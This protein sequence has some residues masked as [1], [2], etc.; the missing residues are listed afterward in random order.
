MD[1]TV[2]LSKKA[3]ISHDRVNS[4][5]QKTHSSLSDPAE[6]PGVLGCKTVLKITGAIQRNWVWELK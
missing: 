2:P 5:L 4:D 6:L 1:G 3:A